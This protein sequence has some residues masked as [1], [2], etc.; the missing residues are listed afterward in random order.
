MTTKELY[1]A[2]GL[3]LGQL[4]IDKVQEGFLNNGF[5][6]I[7]Q[8]D[9]FPLAETLT[10]YRKDLGK[11]T[12]IAS[13]ELVWSAHVGP[14][15]IISGFVHSPTAERHIQTLDLLGEKN[16][17]LIQG[18]EG[19]TD[20]STSRITK[21][22]NV[23]NKSKSLLT[24]NPY[25]YSFNAKDIE[26]KNIKEWASQGKDALEGHGPLYEILIWNAG[27][28]FWIAGISSDITQG[29]ELARKSIL[30]GSAKETLEHL[31]RWSRN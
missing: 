31:I 18:L 9:H 27:V 21:A 23:K 8:P 14:H 19:G 10:K 22:T 20:I 28:Y 17:I 13:M 7:Y 24:I 29:I 25:Q 11:R 15:Q 3:D 4:P 6:L 26:F 30:S 12:P 2:L 1:Q 16:I 5:A